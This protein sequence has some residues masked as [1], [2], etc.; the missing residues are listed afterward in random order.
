MTQKAMKYCY[1]LLQRLKFRRCLLCSGFEWKIGHLLLWK[2]SN[3]MNILMA[4][5]T[6]CVPLWRCPSAPIPFSPVC[7]EYRRHPMREGTV[8]FSEQLM[9]NAIVIIQYLSL[10]IQRLNREILSF[11]RLVS[12]I[13]ESRRVI[14]NR[15]ED[16]GVRIVALL[17]KIM[18]KAW[19]YGL[20]IKTS[21]NLNAVWSMKL[22][23]SSDVK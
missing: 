16:I 10:I 12:R 4:C 7:N 17:G 3:K 8:F 23:S 5:Q 13:C 14:I 19:I 6:H 22:R 15:M 2:P 1:L 11:P 20:G 21:A 9:R 18:F